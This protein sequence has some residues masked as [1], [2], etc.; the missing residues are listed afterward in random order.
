MVTA[1]PGDVLSTPCPLALSEGLPDVLRARQAT[2][3]TAAWTTW[4]NRVSGCV[5]SPASSL[6]FMEYCLLT[7]SPPTTRS[8]TTLALRPVEGGQPGR[9]C[10]TCCSPEA[11]PAPRAPRCRRGRGLP[12]TTPRALAIAA[13]VVVLPESPCA[14]SPERQSLFPGGAVEILSTRFPF[15]SFRNPTNT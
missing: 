11:C 3:S 8:N 13:S 7:N 1:C 2:G 10:G 14:P 9:G 6:D 12:D 5:I 4:G 15:R